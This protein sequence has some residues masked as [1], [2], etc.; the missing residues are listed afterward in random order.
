M[1]QNHTTH[2]RHGIVVCVTLLLFAFVLLS[3]VLAPGMI[4][5]EVALPALVALLRVALAGFHVDQ[6]R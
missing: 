4:S 2:T 3:A 5:L 6:P 1:S